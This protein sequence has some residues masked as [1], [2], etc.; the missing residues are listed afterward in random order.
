MKRTL[1]LGALMALAVPAS[2]QAA[3]PRCHATVGQYE[4]FVRS[5]YRHGKLHGPHARRQ[6]LAIAACLDGRTARRD[7]HSF[8]VKLIDR[9]TMP[10]LEGVASTYDGS[11]PACGPHGPYGIA[12][13]LIPCGHHVQLC[14]GSRCIVAVRQDSGP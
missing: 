14:R 13:L 10:T 12:T 8:R 9:Q 7:A 3:A 2:A 1:I 5:H 11:R 6:L 4:R